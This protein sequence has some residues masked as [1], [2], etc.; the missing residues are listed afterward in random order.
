MQT[1]PPPLYPFRYRMSA[2]LKWKLLKDVYTT[3]SIPIPNFKF[4]FLTVWNGDE[5]AVKTKLPICIFLAYK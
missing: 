5:V 1:C 3:E 4:V 2:N